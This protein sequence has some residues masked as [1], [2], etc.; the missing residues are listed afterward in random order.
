MPVLGTVFNN[1]SN[2]F[3]D[4]S[5]R[6]DALKPAIDNSA[7][8]INNADQLVFAVIPD[9]TPTVDDNAT[10]L[11]NTLNDLVQGQEWFCDRIVGK[12]HLGCQAGAAGSSSLVWPTVFVK[13]GFFVARSIDEAPQNIDLQTAEYDPLEAN[14]AM[15]PWIFQR[16]WMM[17]NTANTTETATTRTFPVFTTDQYGSAYDGP[18][19][20]IKTKRRIRKEERLWMVIRVKGFSSGITL[21]TGSAAAQ[22]TIC[23]MIDLRVHGSMRRAKN[24]SRF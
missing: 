16:S 9:F 19:L 22:P 14:N 13:L 15:N 21:V 8:A 6:V 4:T 10:S 5:I 17:S 24:N 12:V 23:G 3:H 18:H 20:D 1:G 2:H 7:A 11:T